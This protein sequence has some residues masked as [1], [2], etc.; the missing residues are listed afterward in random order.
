MLA[1][2][3]VNKR[4]HLVGNGGAVVVVAAL[5]EEHGVQGLSGKPPCR[6]RVVTGYRRF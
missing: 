1:F 3:L 2:L 6:M 4:E 5:E